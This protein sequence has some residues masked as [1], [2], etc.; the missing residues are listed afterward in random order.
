MKEQTYDDSTIINDVKTS[1][2][3]RIIVFESEETI[4]Q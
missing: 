2:L 3:R 1:A 4:Y